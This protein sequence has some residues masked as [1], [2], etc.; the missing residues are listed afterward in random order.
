M[1]RCHRHGG[2][3]SQPETT[4][5]NAGRVSAS[6]D[7]ALKALDDIDRRLIVLLQD[8]ARLSTVALAKAV[9][10][11]RTTVQERLARLEATGVINGYTLRLGQT[12]Q[13]L[14]AWLLLHHEDGYTCDDVMPALNQ[15][16]QVQQCYS[17]AGQID[18]LVLVR[19]DTAEQ[20]AQLRERIVMLKG[21]ATVTTLPILRVLLDRSA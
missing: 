16:P 17:V 5:H 6:A 11:A 10:L 12:G 1:E 20:L 3:K 7:I 13:A 15:L 8:D 14:Q 4:R 21:V 2:G 19:A 18:L 9:G